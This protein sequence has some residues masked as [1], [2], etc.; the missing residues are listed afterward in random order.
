MSALIIIGVIVSILVLWV[1]TTYNNLISRRIK[2]ETQYSQIDV[3]LKMRTDLIPNLIE[4]VSAYA[5]HEKELINSVTQ[6]REK[7]MGAASLDEEIAMENQLK[8]TLKSLFALSENYPDLKANTN[9]MEMQKQLADIESRIADFRQFYNDT[10]MLYNRLLELFP[11][12]IIAGLFKFQ[13]KDF[14]KAAEQDKEH[15]RVKF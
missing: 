11:S 2:V 10:V 6:S 14:Y 12:S 15:V 4:T 7:M 13:P 5:G 1:I 3:Q 9:F 8:G